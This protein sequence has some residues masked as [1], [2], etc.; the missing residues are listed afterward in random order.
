[1]IIER[2]QNNEIL[3]RLNPNINKYGLQKLLDYIKYLEA[4]SK[5]KAVQSDIDELADEV[6]S[7]WWKKN[8]KR[9][10]K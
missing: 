10:V 6:T 2:N 8:R 3:I 1:M 9:F 7:N 5:C 4:T